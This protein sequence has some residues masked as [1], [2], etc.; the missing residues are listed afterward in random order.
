ML[1][2]PIFVVV[3]SVVTFILLISLYNNVSLYLSDPLTRIPLSIQLLCIMFLV[4]MNVRPTGEDIHFTFDFCLGVLCLFKFLY[5]DCVV[6]IYTVDVTFYSRLRYDD[7]CIKI[8]KYLPIPKIMLTKTSTCLSHIL[9]ETETAK[10][11][12]A[13]CKTIYCCPKLM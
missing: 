6:L 5:Q 13:M 11:M 8:C 12:Y 9:K 4:L 2:H 7:R 3:R 1:S 10:H